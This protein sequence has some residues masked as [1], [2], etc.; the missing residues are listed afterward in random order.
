MEEI[1]YL[2]KP[3]IGTDILRKVIIN[4]EPSFSGLKINFDLSFSDVGDTAKYE[5]VLN[6]PTNNE[7]AKY[8]KHIF[9]LLNSSL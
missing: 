8:E 6:N 2:N 9:I 5:V 3:H 7:I 1:K 4:N